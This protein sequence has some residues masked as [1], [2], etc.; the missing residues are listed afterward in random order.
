MSR[1]AL[2]VLAAGTLCLAG[3]AANAQRLEQ[4]CPNVSY[5]GPIV[6]ATCYNAYMGL[7]RSSIDTSTCA[8][9]VVNVNGQLSCSRGGYG[10]GYGH[11]GGYGGGG[12]PGG[13]YGR[14]RYGY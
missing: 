13:G 14:P 4:T 12:Y 10:G 1:L 5:R 7:V 6:V 8:G 9:P 2:L 11:G 3:T